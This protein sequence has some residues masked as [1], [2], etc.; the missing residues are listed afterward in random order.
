MKTRALLARDRALGP[1]C[2]R[3]RGHALPD[4]L[5]PKTKVGGTAWERVPSVEFDTTRGRCYPVGCS[6]QK[7][8]LLYS[9]A[10][11]GKL[12]VSNNSTRDMRK[13]L[14]EVRTPYINQT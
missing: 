6:Y 5:I 10:A 1:R 9:P 14:L 3:R 11:A 13:E 4:P 2:D 8:K 7:Q 12:S